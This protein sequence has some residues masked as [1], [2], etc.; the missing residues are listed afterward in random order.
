MSNVDAELKTNIN[1]SLD[2][3]QNECTTINILNAYEL[4]E[5]IRTLNGVDNG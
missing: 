4:I 3:L 1:K 2:I 5:E